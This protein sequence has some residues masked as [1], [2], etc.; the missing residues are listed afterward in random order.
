MSIVDA[1]AN[2]NGVTADRRR[3]GELPNAVPEGRRFDPG[4]PLNGKARYSARRLSYR[5]TTLLVVD[6]SFFKSTRKKIAISHL[7]DLTSRLG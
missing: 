3:P 2:T 7:T 6:L 1:R 5:C 4:N